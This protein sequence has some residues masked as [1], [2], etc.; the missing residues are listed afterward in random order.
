MPED[1]HLAPH[2]AARLA[3][4][5]RLAARMDRAFRLPGTRIRLGWDSI[6]GLVPGIGDAL[7]LGP[8]GYIVFEGQRLGVRRRTLA[9]MGLNIGID[10]LIGAVPLVGDLFDVGW[11]ANSRNVQLIRKDVS[12]KTARRASQTPHRVSEV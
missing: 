4:I 8:A 9:R 1:P 5:E 7:T 12:R 6:L 10:A 3:R 2:E 11:K